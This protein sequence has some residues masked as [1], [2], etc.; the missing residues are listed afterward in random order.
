MPGVELCLVRDDLT[1]I[2]P[3][4]YVNGG[5]WWWNDAVGLVAG[6]GMVLTQG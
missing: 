5:A 1:A 2:A 4:L 6:E 3:C